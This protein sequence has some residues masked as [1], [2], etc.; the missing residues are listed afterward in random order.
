MFLT[1]DSRLKKYKQSLEL[2]L[3]DYYQVCSS[4]PAPLTRLLT[5]HMES[6]L[7]YLQPGLSTLN[8]NSMNIDAY[9]HQVHTATDRLRDIVDNINQVIQDGVEKKVKRIEK[10]ILFDPNLAYSKIW[11]VDKFVEVE[12]R[13]VRG[14]AKGLY[15]LVKEVENALQVSFLSFF[16][17]NTGTKWD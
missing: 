16:N 17:R 10:I 2:I 4:V 13:A 11:T 1:Q 6:V 8:W 9:L 12:G 7:H 14:Q 5:P 3:Q 15:D